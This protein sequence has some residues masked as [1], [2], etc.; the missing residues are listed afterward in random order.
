MQYLLTEEEYQ[1]LQADVEIGRRSPS[2]TA[3]QKFCTH[4]A[5]N[6]PAKV[7]WIGEEKPWGCILSRS[8]WYCDSCPARIICPHPHKEYS[9]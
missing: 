4:V 2:K 8:D 1:K 6:M 5:D 9:K 7:K 3:L